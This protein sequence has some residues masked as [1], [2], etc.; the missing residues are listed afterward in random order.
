[1]LPPA[2]R[3]YILNVQWGNV[4]ALPDGNER[5]ELVGLIQGLESQKYGEQVGFLNC[6]Q[7]DGS[8]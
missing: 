1:M 3:Y 4:I 7:T 5:T 8:C 2:G 6:I